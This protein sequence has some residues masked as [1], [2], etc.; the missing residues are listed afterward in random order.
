VIKMAS[1]SHPKRRAPRK[2][3]AKPA[4]DKVATVLPQLHSAVREAETLLTFCR[5]KLKEFMR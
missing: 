2:A 5:R 4:P 1:K 3:A